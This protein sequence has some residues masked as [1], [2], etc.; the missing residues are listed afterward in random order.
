MK[1]NIVTPT[2]PA[3]LKVEVGKKECVTVSIT[4][5]TKEELEE[6]GRKWTVDLIAKQR[7]IQY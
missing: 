2:I 4:D 7:K 3:F 6:V 5:F 1:T